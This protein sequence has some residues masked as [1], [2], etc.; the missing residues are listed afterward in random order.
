VR[1]CQRA[2]DFLGRRTHLA[3]DDGDAFVGHVLALRV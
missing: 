2:P 3:L 1:L